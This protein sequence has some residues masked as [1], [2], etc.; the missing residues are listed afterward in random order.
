METPAYP[1]GG[2]RNEDQNQE[3]YGNFLV[4]PVEIKNQLGVLIE[5]VCL[6][7]SETNQNYNQKMVQN[8]E[9]G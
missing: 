1:E 3:W 6:A 9:L 8:L 5:I 4:C 7:W 2:L